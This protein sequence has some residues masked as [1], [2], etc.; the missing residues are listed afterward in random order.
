MLNHSLLKLHGVTHM[1]KPH[2]GGLNYPEI[3]DTRCK[4]I[5]VDGNTIKTKEEGHIEC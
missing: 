2:L 1:L 3:H 4:N 5:G